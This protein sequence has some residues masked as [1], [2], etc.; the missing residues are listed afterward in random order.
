MLPQPSRTQKLGF[1][2]FEFDPASG[3]LRKHGYRVKLPL[4][5]SQILDA[6]INRAL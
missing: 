1:G 5:P 3:D 2:P 4:Q 6:P